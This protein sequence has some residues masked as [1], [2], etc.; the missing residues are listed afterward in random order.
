M[1][2][3]ILAALGLRK[4]AEARPSAPKEAVLYAI[5]DIHGR[6]DLLDPLIEVIRK[7]AASRPR[8][9]VVGLGDYVDRGADSRGVVDRLLDLAATP[10]IETQFLRG[11]HDQILLDFLADHTIGPYWCR[12]GGRETL[13]SFGVEPPA[14]RKHMERW[15]EARDAFDENL[16]LR[17]LRFFQDLGLSF[18]WGDYFFAHAG[19]Q[20]GVPLEEQ[21]P[22]DLM[23]IRKDFLEDER[24]FERVVVHGHTPAEDAYADH[25]RVGL[26][27]GAYMTGVLTACRFEGEARRLIQSMDRPDG[28]PELHSR[29][30]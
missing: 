2:P 28:P 7:E 23:W 5:G 27:T 20:P 4:P 12:V 17:R 13:F 8:T 30:F 16:T 11:N 22:Q 6:T 18:T 25:R 19:A 15:R 29:D 10:G 1:W 3:R 24:R 21:T 26:D 9:I 14:T